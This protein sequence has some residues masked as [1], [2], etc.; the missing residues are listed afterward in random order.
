M[1]EEPESDPLTVEQK[2]LVQG[3]WEKV[4]PIADTAAELFY[5]KLF[6]LDP[7]V[8]PMFANSDMKEQG[9]KFMAIDLA[10]YMAYSL[11]MKIANIAELKNNLSKF[12][13]FVESGEV[14]EI[15]K[16]NIPIARLVPLSPKRKTNR[17]RL[18]CGYGSVQ[19]H[20][21]LTEPMV[22]EADWDML[23]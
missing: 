16:R 10:I 2:N 19:I 5:S 20:S 4:I 15:C 11:A 23:K 14:I 17:T 12:I 3:S 21:D 8:K 1:N 18:G 13:T 7:E 6:E 9:E 22:P